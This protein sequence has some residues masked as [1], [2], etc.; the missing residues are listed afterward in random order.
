M[1]LYVVGFQWILIQFHRA[2]SALFLMYRIV[3]VVVVI[4]QF[5]CI[6]VICTST[7]IGSILICTLR[8]ENANNTSSANQYEWI[9]LVVLFQLKYSKNPLPANDGGKVK[10]KYSLS[11]RIN[12]KKWSFFSCRMKSSHLILIHHRTSTFMC[13]N[14]HF[15]NTITIW[16]RFRL[17][18]DSS[19]LLQMNLY[20][21]YI[22]YVGIAAIWCSCLCFDWSCTITTNHNILAHVF[23][24]IDSSFITQTHTFYMRCE[25]IADCV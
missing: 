12:K 15:I 16:S 5:W 18:Y 8:I 19:F 2:Q 4:S 25:M 22:F 20:S 7:K 9:I 17:H 24:W 11:N 21:E 1:F 6:V 14:G 23:M 10:K 3:V 13:N